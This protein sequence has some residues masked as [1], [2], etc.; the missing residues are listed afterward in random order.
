MG[1]IHRIFKTVHYSS[2]ETSIFWE[3]SV[4]TCLV[5][6]STMNCNFEKNGFHFT[7]TQVLFSPV[8]FS[9]VFTRS[10][11]RDKPAV[12]HWGAKSKIIPKLHFYNLSVSTILH[13]FHTTT[14]PWVCL[15]AFQQ[16]EL[17]DSWTTCFG[18][19]YCWPHPSV[20]GDWKNGRRG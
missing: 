10:R 17:Y 3:V 8:V 7:A 12:W 13:S 16:C 6:I 19:F 1:P 14:Y 4:F 15:I 5:N 20:Q 18:T 9:V 2:H 11:K